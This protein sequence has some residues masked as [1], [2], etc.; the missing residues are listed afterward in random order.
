MCT[1][2]S[3]GRNFIKATG[4]PVAIK[5]R[6]G[7]RSRPTGREGA[8]WRNRRT[9]QPGP[10]RGLGARRLRLSHSD[11]DGLASRDHSEVVTGRAV[12]TSERQPDPEKGFSP[13]L[14]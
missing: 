6:R 14:N 8:S 13:F 4:V 9:G 11:R 5:S 2:N 12:V 7:A 10:V 3:Y 1:I